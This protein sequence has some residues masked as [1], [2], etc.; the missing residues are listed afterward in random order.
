MRKHLAVFFLCLVLPPDITL[1]ESDSQQVLVME[2]YSTLTIAKLYR[3]TKFLTVSKRF[4]GHQAKYMY[5]R[6]RAEQTP[7]TISDIFD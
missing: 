5:I 1:E 4:T 2:V 7:Q 3:K 6:A